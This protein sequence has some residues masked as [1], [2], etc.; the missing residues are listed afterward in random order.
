M[1]YRIV[2]FLRECSL[3]ARPNCPLAIKEICMNK[4]MRYCFLLVIF[5]G[6]LVQDIF[7]KGIY[8]KT[9]EIEN[10]DKKN[11]TNLGKQKKKGFNQLVEK[12]FSYEVN[13]AYQP[14]IQ[15]SVNKLYNDKLDKASFGTSVGLFIP[16]WQSP[17]SYLVFIYPRFFKHPGEA[18]EGNVHLGYRYLSSNNENLYGIYGSYDWNQG[19]LGNNFNQLTFGVETW[20][21]KVFIGGRYYQPIGKTERLID[22]ANGTYAYEGGYIWAKGGYTRN[23]IALPGGD[24]E[25]GYEVTKGFIGYIGGYYFDKQHAKTIY[26]PQ[27]RLVYNWEF[28]RNKRILG[29]FDKLS[30]EAGLRRDEPRGTNLYLRVNLM[31]GL[32]PEKRTPE[33]VARH[34][35]DLIQRDAV[36]LQ[37][38]KREQAPF[39]LAKIQS[40]TPLSPLSGRPGVT[41]AQDSR[42]GGVTSQIGRQDVT[43]AQDSRVGGVTSQIGR[44][45]VTAAQDFRVVEAP[46]PSSD[47]AGVTPA[48]DSRADR[49]TSQIGKPGI[50]AAQDFRVIVKVLPIV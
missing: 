2:K 24:I 29:V 42:V 47:R 17:P 43:A 5:L 10:V 8:V 41:E 37:V 3:G 21:K 44:P 46:A 16:V 30:L 18:R 14:Y 28:T 38:V 36:V 12:N 25:L 40:T 15:L 4:K 9:T 22:I 6:V 13:D 27:V 20:C 19:R 1:V 50:T 23:E 31:I 7:A 45:D 34:M 48:Q 35:V 26:G 49:D 39:I 33:G 32:T 11:D